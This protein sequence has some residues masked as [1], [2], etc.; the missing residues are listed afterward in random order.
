MDVREL[1][2]N[3]QKLELKGDRLGAAAKLEAAGQVYMKEGNSKR[4]AQ[5]L[6]YA[7]KLAPDRSEIVS[8]L[9]IAESWGE[10]GEGIAEAWNEASGA[11]PMRPLRGPTRADP[12]VDAWCSFCCR[13]DKE[14]GLLVAGPAGA[15]ICAQ[16]IASAKAE[17]DGAPGAVRAVSKAEAIT[18]ETHIPLVTAEDVE[19]RLT[20][21]L[22]GQDAA[23][24]QVMNA[25]KLFWAGPA[26]APVQTLAIAGPA[27][28]GKSTALSVLAGPG[29]RVTRLFDAAVAE[30]RAAVDVA[31]KDSA[32]IL[33]DNAQAWSEGEGLR[34]LRDACRRGGAMA[35]AAF[36]VS[37][38]LPVE[39]TIRAA[40]ADVVSTPIHRLNATT[41]ADGIDAVVVF[42]ALRPEAL[43]AMLDAPATYFPELSGIA[44]RWMVTQPAREELLKMAAKAKSVEAM[45]R[46]LLAAGLA[47]AA[48]QA[49]DEVVV[50][51]VVPA[52]AQR[53]PRRPNP[54]AP[55]PKGKGEIG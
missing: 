6:R 29:P 12:F 24:R 39:A 22:V 44:P 50:D 51:G 23:L 43:T 9:K 34:P 36:T 25:V 38:P 47:A 48:G 30:M 20:S 40:S 3:A 7:V 26:S 17:L 41:L 45:R 42:E 2:R 52:S 27:A 33:V 31:Q 53:K 35:V 32:L 1:I 49:R 15:F 19:A 13:P 21:R 28:T 14:V 16:C 8:A 5:V 54:V 4:A 46:A 37:G 18:A 11:E 55:V 10:K